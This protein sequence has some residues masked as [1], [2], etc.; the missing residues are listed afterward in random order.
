MEQGLTIFDHLGAFRRRAWI[1]VLAIAIGTPLALGIAFVLPPV[2]S[3]TAKILVESEQI[4]SD[5]ARSTVTASAAERLQLIEQRLMTRE[6]LLGVIERLGLFTDRPDMTPS[7]KVE[8]VRDST[9]IENDS[10][11]FGD[12]SSRRRGPV[13]VAAFTITFEANRAILAA[14]VANEFVTMIIERNLQSRNKRA[15]ETNVF[16]KTEIERLAGELL[17][18][19]GQ[20]TA[21]KRD[22]DA[23]LPDSLRFRR[24]EIADLDERMFEREQ[25]RFG[26]EESKRALEQALITGEGTVERRLTRDEQQLR[27][28]ELTYAQQSAIYSENHPTLRAMAAR[29]KVLR[30]SINPTTAGSDSG[31]FRDTEITQQIRLID[32]QL[33]LHS[34]QRAVDDARKVALEASIAKTPDVEMVLNALN[35]RHSELQVQYEQAVLNQADAEIGEKLEINRQAE[36]FEIIEQAVVP[37]APVA[38]NRPLIAVGGTFG[39]AVLGVALMLLVETLSTTIRTPRD[40][41]RRLDL[42]PVVTIP[43]IRTDF[44]IR[45]R[46]LRT[47]GVVLAVLVIVPSGL[48]A[49][50]QYYLPLSLLAERLLDMAGLNEFLQLID[51]RL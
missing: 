18:I 51:R 47:T 26:L 6:N 35:R 4:P 12:S 29:I 17:A 13:S 15:A 1:L 44:E 43:Y 45:R 20:I 16:F 9:L 10:D 42:R 28:L 33:A 38:P 8:E 39:S 40:L 24:A 27:D 2:Y 30:R 7:Q 36:R 50:D 11:P 48:Y 23:A 22:N 46:R 34:K 41:E 21:Y 49:V 37:D 25:R 5:L 14:S 31:S 3:S 19:E 32:T